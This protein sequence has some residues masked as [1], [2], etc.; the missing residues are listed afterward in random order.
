M[1]VTLAEA[2]R[3]VEAGADVVLMAGHPFEFNPAVRELRRLLDRGELGMLLRD[4]AAAAVTPRTRAIIAVHLYGQPCDVDG[5]PFGLGRAPR[6]GAGRGRGASARGHLAP[7]AS[8]RVDRCCVSLAH[9]P[10]SWANM[11]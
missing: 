7:S 9:L 3:L 8:G 1:T 4:A 10:I 11:C 5:R 2:H 6:P